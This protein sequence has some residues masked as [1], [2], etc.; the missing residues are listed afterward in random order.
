MA[1]YLRKSVRFGPLRLN[2]SKSGLGVSA[3]VKGLRIG[4]GPRGNYI[5]ASRGG[6][7][8]RKTLPSQKTRQ[9]RE[10][11]RLQPEPVL[12]PETGEEVSELVDYQ[13]LESDSVVRMVDGDASELLDEL[14]ERQHRK[15][16]WPFVGTASVATLLW[17]LGITN[18]PLLLVGLVGTVLATP[19]VALWD[20]RRKTTVLLYDLEPQLEEAYRKVYEQYEALKECERLWHIEGAAN[21]R[22]PKY[23]A[24]A[25]H[26]IKRNRVTPFDKAPKIIRTNVP[27]PTLPA[28]KQ[29]LCFFPDRLLVF[30]SNRVG[31]VPYH[32]LEVD[33]Q[34]SKFIE[35]ERVPSDA[36]V[37]DRTWRYVNKRGRPDKRFKDNKELPVVLYEELIFTSDS[38]LQEHYQLSKPGVADAFKKAVFGLTSS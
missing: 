12:Q 6:I 29:H 20:R 9:R 1:F 23:H 30:E 2:L 21:F 7:Y 5:H 33:I 35:E 13:E 31:A 28:G 4:A 3:G 36:R 11:Q 19:I 34:P 26:G 15:R 10:P 24:G 25:T 27:V 17:G 18:A 22:D 38:G 8:Y 14:N 16:M 37:I 32:E